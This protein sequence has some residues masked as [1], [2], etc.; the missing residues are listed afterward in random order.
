MVALLIVRALVRLVRRADCGVAAAVRRAAHGDARRR[1]RVVLANWSIL[2]V[3]TASLAI[4]SVLG[5]VGIARFLEL[6]GGI[7][8]P[9]NWAG[10]AT[11]QL[12]SIIL[13]I[14]IAQRAEQGLPAPGITAGFW[15]R[16]TAEAC[17]QLTHTD[18]LV[19]KL[20][21]ASFSIIAGLGYQLL[22]HSKGEGHAQE[23]KD[24]EGTWPSGGWVRCAGSAPSSGCR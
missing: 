24:A 18:N 14:M 7:A 21:F 22:R 11:F 2:G 20:L 5:A 19:G 1:V 4:T 12:L 15:A 6:H 10:V 13:M 3:L 23:L 16:V 8:S 17:F 9:W